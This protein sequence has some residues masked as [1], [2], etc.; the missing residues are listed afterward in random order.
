AKSFDCNGDSLFDLADV[1]CC[2][3]HL[4][5]GP[6]C[7][8]C[9]VDSTRD[10]PSVRASFGDPIVTASGLDI[11]LH[12]SGCDRVGAAR[13]ALRVPSSRFPF[14]GAETHESH[15]LELHQSGDG[16]AAVGLIRIRPYIEVIVPA[17]GESMDIIVHLALR[18]GASRGGQIS[19]ATSEF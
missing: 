3:M 19:L 10:E 17:G 13:L 4:L 1:I 7:P 12:V 14:A 16:S 15:W 18:P 9:P 6:D 2:A 5:S 11:P 8:D